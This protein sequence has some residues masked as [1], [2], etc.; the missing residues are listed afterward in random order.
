MK[1]L[2]PV[3]VLLAAALALPRVDAQ[4]GSLSLVTPAPNNGQA[5]TMFDLEPTGGVPLRI[6]SFVS[7][8]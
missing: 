8:R 7:T 2:F 5:G 1:S 3:T 6:E 4:C